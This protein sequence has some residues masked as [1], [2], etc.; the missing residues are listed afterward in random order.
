M[1]QRK[2][3]DFYNWHFRI[4]APAVELLRP[5]AVIAIV[6]RLDRRVV[7]AWAPQVSQ[8]VRRLFEMPAVARLDLQVTVGIERHLEMARGGRRDLLVVIDDR[9]KL[10]MTRHPSRR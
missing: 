10:A 2:K 3:P 7:A 1:A 8:G 6:Q 4:W 9:S 5:R